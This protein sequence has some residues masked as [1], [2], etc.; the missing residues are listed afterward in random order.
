MEVARTCKEK[1]GYVAKDLGKEFKKYDEKKKTDDGKYVLSNK[2][3]KLV[4]K[5][6]NGG[7]PVEIDVGYERFLGPEMFFHPEFIHQDW[8]SPLDEI[9][10]N[11]IQACPMD[12]RRRLYQNI[13]LSGGSTLFDG[14]DVKLGKL[15]Q[16]R[17]NNRLN[18]YKNITGV[19]SQSIPVEV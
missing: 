9:I 19:E 13:V 4:H 16:S 5:P 8:K 12:Y 17:V 18:A 15:V 3:K 14:F 10:D 7:K 6:S 1:Y 11:S 2:F